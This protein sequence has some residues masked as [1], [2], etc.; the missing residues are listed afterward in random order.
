V[1]CGPAEAL[2]MALSGRAA[3]VADLRGDGA[4]LLGSRLAAEAAAAG[5]GTVRLTAGSSSAWTAA[6]SAGEPR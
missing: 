4:E 5:D 2:V 3:A 1:V 6:A